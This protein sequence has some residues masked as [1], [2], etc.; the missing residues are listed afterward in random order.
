MYKET[1]RLWPAIPEIARGVDADLNIE[2]YQIPQNTWVQVIID[3]LELDLYVF[4]IIFYCLKVSTYVNA[5]QEKY[6]PEPEDFRPERFM[7]EE[8]S[9]QYTHLID[10][11]TYFPFSLGPRGCIGQNLAHV[12][13]SR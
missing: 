13:F 4:L 12:S 5:R 10:N 2:G 11:Y 8:K 6:F 3:K 9:G 7:V 1:L